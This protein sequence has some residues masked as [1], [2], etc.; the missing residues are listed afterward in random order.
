MKKVLFVI[1]IVLLLFGCFFAYKSYAL[2]ILYNF[3][4]F[5]I[6]S[7]II[8]RA[9]N[10]SVGDTITIEH[11]DKIGKNVIEYEN[12]KVKNNFKG[13]VTNEFIH[14]DDSITYRLKEDDETKAAFQIHI[15]KS[16]VDSIKNGDYSKEKY[17]PKQDVFNKLLSDNNI[18]DDKDL[19]N[20]LIN[21]R[22]KQN[23]IYTS[24]KNMRENY[25]I[26]YLLYLIL[27]YDEIRFI[28]G[29]Y[30]GYYRI[31]S[32]N[33][34]IDIKKDDKYYIFRFYSNE[35]FSLDFVLDVMST[36]V[37]E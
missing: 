10:I 21:N 15:S 33:K 18:N 37:I 5:D 6:D 1:C 8:E 32:E 12:V 4:K 20:F 16:Y 13:F 27:P 23:N 11:N 29:D 30:D 17:S 19:I 24:I 28:D 3:N 36:L 34:I 7:V 25:A 22:D 31:D 2:N 26:K 9:N 14:E 35:Y